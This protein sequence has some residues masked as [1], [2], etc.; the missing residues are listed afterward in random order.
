VSNRGVFRWPCRLLT[1]PAGLY[2]FLLLRFDPAL[3]IGLFCMAFST[4]C[5]T[6]SFRVMPLRAA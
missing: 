2:Y 6:K 3:R 1:Q 4:A 5:I